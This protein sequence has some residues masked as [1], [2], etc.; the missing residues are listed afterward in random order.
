VEVAGIFR[1]QSG[2][3][4]S[5]SPANGGPDFDGDGLFNGQGLYFDGLGNPLYARNS[6]TA[7]P[8]V[9]M[10]MRIAKRFNI[11]ERVKGQVLFEMFNLFNR[12]NT[13]AVQALQGGTPSLGSTLQYLPGREGQIGVRF[14]F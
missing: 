9:N 13:A 6:Q 8:S 10:D 4:Y 5:V 3:R 14:D 2:F 11:G 7:P 1:A 12:D